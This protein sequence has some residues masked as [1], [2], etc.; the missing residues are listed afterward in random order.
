MIIISTF[1]DWKRNTQSFIFDNKTAY[2]KEAKTH[3]AE[4][5]HLEL[6]THGRDDAV[7]L[8]KHYSYM[9]LY[10]IGGD[11]LGKIKSYFRNIGKRYG[12]TREFQEMDIL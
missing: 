4:I 10:G 1:I 2:N 7:A 6:R 9:R 8:A 11:D 3:F 5:D 12:I